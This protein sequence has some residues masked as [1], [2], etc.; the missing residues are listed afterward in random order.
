MSEIDDKEVEELLGK[1]PLTN[2]G[3]YMKMQIRLLR[4]IQKSL[5]TQ[6]ITATLEVIEEPAR[7]RRYKKRIRE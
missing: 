7:K 1:N 6:P 5:N 4:S 2:A 3:E